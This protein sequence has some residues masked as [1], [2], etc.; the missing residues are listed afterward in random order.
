MVLACMMKSTEFSVI[1]LLIETFPRQNLLACGEVLSLPPVVADLYFC[2]ACCSLLCYG[3]VVLFVCGV[4]GV[5]C[6]LF[7]FF[8]KGYVYMVVVCNGLF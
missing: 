7:L 4:W 5:G 6:Y 1:V 8:V 3:D 2:V